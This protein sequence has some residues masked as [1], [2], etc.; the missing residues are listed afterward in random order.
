MVKPLSEPH[1]PAR[2]F[3]THTRFITHPV[4]SRTPFHHTHPV[5]SRTPFH[6]APRFITHPVSSRTP[7]HHAP[8]FITHPVSSRTP[9]HHAPRFITHPVSSRTP[10]SSPTVSP[11][12]SK[13]IK[14]PCVRQRLILLL[15]CPT[16]FW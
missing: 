2:S 13:V 3:I 4:S 10:F 6:H 7:F 9:F 8:R 5:S 15:Y 14:S 1:H 16:Q 11:L 12:Q